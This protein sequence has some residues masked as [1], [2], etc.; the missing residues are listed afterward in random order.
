MWAAV[1]TAAK[2]N[3]NTALTGG[4]HRRMFPLETYVPMEQVG[5]CLWA[6]GH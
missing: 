4:F 2:T 1:S 5:P 6:G 3:P